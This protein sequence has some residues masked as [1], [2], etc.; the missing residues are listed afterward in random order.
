MKP[1]KKQILGRLEKCY[2]VSAMQVRGETYFFFASELA[3]DGVFFDAA[4]GNRR[5]TFV[6]PGGV[7]SMI[8]WPGGEGGFLSVFGFY[9]PFQAAGSGLMRTVFRENGPESREI[10]RLPYLHRFLL[11]QTGSHCWL[12]AATVCRSKAAKDDW[13]SPGYV[14]LF[15]MNDQGEILCDKPEILLDGQYR[16]HGMSRG[17]VDGRSAILTASDQGVFAIY[18]GE[19]LR[20]WQVLRMTEDASSEAAVFDL[21]GD[22]EEELI[23]IAPFHGSSLS[24]YKK[25]GA[26]NWE[27]VWTCREE[28]PFSHALWAGW[29]NGERTCFLG[30]RGGRR[31]LLRI[32]FLEDQ[33]RTDVIDSDVGTSNLCVVRMGK[34]DWLLAANHGVGECVLYRP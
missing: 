24:I 32:R 12:V 7:M 14:G 25:A 6:S 26:G 5:E 20:D 29:F 30:Y 19:L 2:S 15:P 13:S 23:T 31:D 28:L 11:T 10:L 1:L 21:D 27:K 4:T 17:T 34:E 16:N 18:P 8:A 33:W 9:P 22:G 3:H